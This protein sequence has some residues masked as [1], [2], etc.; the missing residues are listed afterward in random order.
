MVNELPYERMLQECLKGE[1]RVLNAHL[2]DKQKSLSDLL[3]EEEPNVKCNDGSTHLFKRKELEYLAG[4]IDPDEQPALLLPVI[5]EVNPGQDEM[6]VIC[7]SQVEARVIS[8]V[9]NM[10][11]SPQ[12]GRIV[13]YKPQLTVLRKLLR[14]TTQIVFSPRILE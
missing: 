2:P 3:P 7:R 14:T 8:K 4:L 11:V 5:I 1:L 13:I 9:L 6:A 12:Q 10:P